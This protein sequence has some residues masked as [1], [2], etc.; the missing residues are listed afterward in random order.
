MVELLISLIVLIFF[1]A[2]A[3]WKQNAVVFLLAAGTAIV[4]AFAWY[5]TYTTNLGLGI[6]LMI[7][8]YA[9]VCMGWGFRLLFWREE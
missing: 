3:L 5:D 7:V 1:S 8:A 4:L 6:S 9:L 2:V